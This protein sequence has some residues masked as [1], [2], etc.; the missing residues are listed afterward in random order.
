M[1]GKYFF[2]YHTYHSKA[3]NTKAEPWDRITSRIKYKVNEYEGLSRAEENVWS[4]GKVSD[5]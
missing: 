3:S 1:R 4:F 2:K 5:F